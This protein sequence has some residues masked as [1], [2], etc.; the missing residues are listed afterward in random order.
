M[1]EKSFQSL[2]DCHRRELLQLWQRNVDV[3]AVLE[4]LLKRHGEAIVD[5]F[6]RRLQ[7]HPQAAAFLAEEMIDR[8]LRQ[9]VAAWLS[10]TFHG[11]H[12][13][14]VEEFLEYQAR[15]GQMHADI[16]VPL[17]LF[18]LGLR[19][20]K[21]E[22][23][24]KVELL[25]PRYHKR[26][27]LYID[28]L[29]DL[30]LAIAAESYS[31]EHGEMIS[32]LQRL[33]M[34]IPPENLQLVCE[35]MRNRLLRWYAEQLA[36]LHQGMLRNEGGY[37]LA[38]LRESE[39]GLW[40]EHK[41][42]LLFPENDTLEKLRQACREIDRQIDRIGRIR[43]RDAGRTVARLEEEMKKADWLL[44]ELGREVAEMEGRTDPLT[45]LFNRR[46]LN[47]VMNFG[48]RRARGGRQYAVILLDI[49]HFKQIND[50]YGHDVGDQ[51]LKW[52]A[53]LLGEKVRSSDFVFRYGG[54][55]FL[56]L[57]PAVQASTAFSVAEKLRR[58]LEKTPFRLPDGSRISLT[59]SCGIAMSGGEW[60]YERVIKRADQALYRA[61]R[62]GR[63]RCVLADSEN[64]PTD[65]V[66]RS[67]HGVGRKLA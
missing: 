28:G 63:N 11:A 60:H 24:D 32:E 56:I 61:K 1:A 65:R 17:N 37:G 40:L 42:P 62:Q 54:E 9:G 66:S 22:L 7:K 23:I 41:A 50:T 5:G 10:F 30:V 13:Q 4:P 53:D 64:P 6:Y 38:P 59:V 3:F 67:G 43:F 39:V 29:L 48:N 2:I 51:V 33:R 44:V 49:D 21:A 15:L 45:Q 55:E 25:E 35:Q 46:H 52:F 47:T 36:A 20:L 12:A 31:E 34:S 14:T 27:I 57:L 26:A 19:A 16:D 58:E 18:L 8:R